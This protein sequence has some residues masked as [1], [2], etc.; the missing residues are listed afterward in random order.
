M[1]LLLQHVAPELADEETE[2]GVRTGARRADP[3]FFT[4]LFVL[5]GVF[6]GFR[7]GDLTVGAREGLA[8]GAEPL[9]PVM[10]TSAQLIK[11]SGAASGL[12]MS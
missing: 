1:S 2:L 6:T 9:P 12:A 5:E 8:T 4:G 11:I 10:A 7:V 3:L